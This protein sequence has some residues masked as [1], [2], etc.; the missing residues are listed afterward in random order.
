[1][2]RHL[3]YEIT[4]IFYFQKETYWVEVVSEM[5]FKTHEI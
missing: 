1:M 2:A 5:Y 4:V 3:E